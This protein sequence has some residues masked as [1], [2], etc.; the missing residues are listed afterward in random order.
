MSELPGQRDGQTV[1]PREIWL[2]GQ[3]RIHIP[4]PLVLSKYCHDGANTGRTDEIRRG[5]LLGFDSTLNQWVN[6]KYT[7]VASG[8]SGSGTGAG[9]V[10]L[11]VDNA[12]A[13]KAGEVVTITTSAGTVTR[14]ISS[15]NYST[16]VITLTAA[17]DNPSIGGAVYVSTY[18]DGTSATGIKTARAVLDAT[19]RLLSGEKYDTDL[20]S[21]A[22]NSPGIAIAGY[23]DED[24]VL[25]DLSAAQADSGAKLSQF[26]FGNNHGQT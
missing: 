23:L 4:G 14:T 26:A 6:L 1:T 20:Y 22:V 13:F 10:N 18:A 3:G 7:R 11:T 5:W 12:A 16:N 9:D 17:V 19:T 25:G 8:T 2:S 24:M 15:V 21:K